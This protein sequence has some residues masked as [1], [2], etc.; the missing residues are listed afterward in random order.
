MGVVCGVWRGGCEGRADARRGRWK[1]REREGRRKE[2][3]RAPLSASLHSSVP[4]LVSVPA[5]FRCSPPT[6]TSRPAWPACCARLRCPPSEC[7][8]VLGRREGAKRSSRRGGIGRAA[9][10][11]LSVATAP[12]G[13]SDSSGRPRPPTRG[14][15]THGLRPRGVCGSCQWARVRR[16]VLKTEGRRGHWGAT[17]ALPLPRAASPPRH[18]RSGPRHPYVGTEHAFGLPP[19]ANWRAWDSVGRAQRPSF[20]TPASARLPRAR[21]RCSTFSSLS[22]GPSPPT[23]PPSPPSPATP[24]P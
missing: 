21:G 20:L 4:T 23:R 15:D 14:S 22:L 17:K 13:R 16:A 11:L 8:R 12:G 2:R 6:S 10:A 9:A 5:A 7:G 3:K 24:L 18:A 1:G 19:L